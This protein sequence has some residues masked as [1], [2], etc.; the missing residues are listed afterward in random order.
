MHRTG[1]RTFVVLLAALGYVPSCP[2]EAR[3]ASDT[4]AAATTDT[5]EVEQAQPTVE[6]GRFHIKELR[7]TRNETIELMFSIQLELA[8]TADQTTASQLEHWRHRLRDQVII[9]V[10]VA[11]TKDFTEPGLDRLRQMILRRINRLFKAR[12]VQEILLD[13]FTFSVE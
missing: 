8:R 1:I 10:R 6:L 3:G 4:G 12:V 11:E 13:E 9:A 5:T 2:V 7:F